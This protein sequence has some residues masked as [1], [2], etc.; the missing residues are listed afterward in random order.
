M[1]CSNPYPK[2]MRVQTDWR[3][4]PSI[5]QGKVIQQ[6][7]QKRSQ[8]SNLYAIVDSAQAFKPMENDD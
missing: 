2:G 6:D 3:S 5:K 8:A 7:T 4:S 1:D